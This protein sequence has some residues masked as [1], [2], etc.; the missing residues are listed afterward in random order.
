M[1]TIKQPVHWQELQTA[2]AQVLIECGMK[3]EVEKKISTARGDVSVDVFA[4]GDID[5]IKT[6]IVCEC[7]NWQRPVE[8]EKVYA[9]R[10][11]VQDCGA[12]IAYIISKSGFYP[13]SYSST[14]FTNVVLC[15][16]TEFLK[17]FE[18]KW[19]KQHFVPSITHELDQ[20]VTLMEPREPDWLYGLPE[21]FQDDVA[22]FKLKYAGLAALAMT[23]SK[24]GMMAG[25]TI[26]DLP[27]SDNWAPSL[28]GSLSSEIVDAKGY[29]E[30][31]DAMIQ[32]S[33]DA[34]SEL[35][36]IKNQSY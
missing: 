16:W 11:I 32:M 35:L 10:T 7:K 23:T 1:I 20:I 6:V 18:K 15:N 31:L 13:G 34:I 21:Q 14:D 9:V 12:N 27:L 25:E 2:T 26:P 24:Y 22:D 19:L 28:T 4:Q 36:S 5:G 8:Q 33:E 3:A 29:R 17:L 30:L